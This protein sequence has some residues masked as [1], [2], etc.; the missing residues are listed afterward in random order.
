VNAELLAIY[1]IATLLTL[2][3]AATDLGVRGKIFVQL[4]V[5]EIIYMKDR[6]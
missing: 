5:D 3:G 1:F 4:L 6:K 2:V